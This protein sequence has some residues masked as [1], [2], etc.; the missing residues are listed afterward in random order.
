MALVTVVL[1][2][3]GDFPMMRRLLKGIKARAERVG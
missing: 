2:E 1:M 3:F